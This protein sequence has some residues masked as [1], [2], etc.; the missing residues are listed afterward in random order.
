MCHARRVL[1]VEDT[2]ALRQLLAQALAD[3]G[4][5]VRTAADGVHALRLLETL[6]PCLILLDLRMPVM[7]GWD[8]ARAYRARDSADAHIV[9][10]TAEPAPGSLD[11][12]Q[13]VH[14][15]A[16]PFDLEELLPV[17]ERWVLAHAPR[18]A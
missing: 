6:A 3:E 17:V 5:T 18:S 1:V 14:V 10:L 12:I 13:P 11:D 7:D 9:V 15:A 2:P 4:Y 8:F 16:K